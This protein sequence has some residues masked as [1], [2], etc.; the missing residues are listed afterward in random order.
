MQNPLEHC[1]AAVQLLPFALG[2]LAQLPAPSQERPCASSETQ[3]GASSSPDGTNEHVPRLDARLQTLQRSLQSVSQ[4][5]PSEQWPVAHSLNEPHCWP[6]GLLHC[7]LASHAWSDAQVS[8]GSPAGTLA[9][10]PG[11]P[12]VLQDLQ[13]PLHWAAVCV[14][15]TPST[16][17]PDAQFDAVAAV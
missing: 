5:T 13:V 7:W 17:L 4:Q 11:L 6:S 10:S 8:S 16:Q 12:A 2:R 3:V 15:Q 1:A 14:Q 9:Q